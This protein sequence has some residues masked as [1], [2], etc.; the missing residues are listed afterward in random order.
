MPELSYERLSL[1]EEAKNAAASTS[2][3]TGSPVSLV[4]PP[5]YYEEGPFD[6]PSSDDEDDESGSLLEK[7][8]VP[9]SPG[10]A[11]LGDGFPSGSGDQAIMDKKVRTFGGFMLAGTPGWKPIRKPSNSFYKSRSTE[12]SIIAIPYYIAPLARW[13]VRDYWVDSCPNVYRDTTT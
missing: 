5:I 13:V 10:L 9:S 12:T 8:K 11:E 2:S 4:R 3:R 7:R 1:K 6:P